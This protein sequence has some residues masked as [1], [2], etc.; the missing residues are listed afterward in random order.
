M[1]FLK[2]IAFFI[3]LTLPVLLKA[4]VHEVSQEKNK[5]F[6]S[7]FNAAAR[8]DTLLLKDGLF[9]VNEFIIDKPVTIMNS[10][11]AIIDGENKAN[12]IIIKSDSVN[13]VSLH[14]KNSGASSSVDYSGIRVEKSGFLKIINCTLENTFFGIYLSG[15]NTS[16]LMNN[17]IF[18][19]AE[20]ETFSGNGIHIWKSENITISGNQISGHRDGIYFEF[21]TNS[22]INKNTS[23]NNLRYGL[24]FMFS[25]GNS[26]IE[27][28]F[29]K[30]GAGVA[31]MY[32]KDIIMQRNTF[33][34]NWG[35]ASYGLLLKDISRSDITGNYFHHNTV[36]LFMEGST[37]L[38]IKQ[39]VFVA[40]GW[41]IK[42]LGNCNDN[43]VSYNNFSGNTFDLMT[44]SASNRNTVKSN[45]WDKYNGYDLDKNYI[46]DVPFRP[47]SAFGKIAETTPAAVILLRSFMVE[48]YDK[49]ERALPSLHSANIV[50]ERPLMAPFN[51]IN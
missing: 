6:K 21:V 25:N 10:G 28:V 14:L 15:V 33:K 42:I 11:N 34:D 4:E 18:S 39:N 35:P 16:S 45:Y 2:T 20:K 36:A 51:R 23:R 13:L 17:K 48:L 5:S 12:I 43:I 22:S 19:S 40:N 31:V 9:Y 7:V 24:H 26:Y 30:N 44:N 50:D 3:F 29:E 41:A 8:H 32:T 46:G 1:K 47:V 38:N 37:N 49:I 27:N